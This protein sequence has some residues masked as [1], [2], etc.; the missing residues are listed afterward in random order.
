MKPTSLRR[1]TRPTA[2][3]RG[4]TI[5]ELIVV[6]IVVGILGAAAGSRF[7]DRSVSDSRTFADQSAALV[8]Y[9]QKL[10]IAQNRDVWVVLASGGIKLCYSVGC[11]APERVT[12]PGGSNSATGATTGFCDGSSSWACEAPPSGLSFGTTIEFYFD[13]M[14]KPF[15]SGGAL[16]APQTISV[17]GGPAARSFTVEMETGYVH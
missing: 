14:G 1:C 5:I 10:A 9:A 13:A 8:R 12:A 2:L 17:I 11:T 6:I 15:G 3:Q 16:A 7:F 4:F